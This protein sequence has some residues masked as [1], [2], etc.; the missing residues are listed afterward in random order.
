MME[1][2]YYCILHPHKYSVNITNVT[3]A[4]AKQFTTCIV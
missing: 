3:G 2:D 4:N 1:A